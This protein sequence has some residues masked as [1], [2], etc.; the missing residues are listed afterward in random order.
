[1]H[2][3]AYPFESWKGLFHGGDAWEINCNYG[4]RFDTDTF[5]FGLCDDCIQAK[6]DTGLLTPSGSIRP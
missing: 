2:A 3:E 4:S 6:V 1:M 5:V